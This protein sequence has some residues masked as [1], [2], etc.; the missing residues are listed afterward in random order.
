[1][2]GFADA[3]GNDATLVVQGLDPAELEDRRSH[4][5]FLARELRPEL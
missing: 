4:P 2:L 1:V 5:N 3:E